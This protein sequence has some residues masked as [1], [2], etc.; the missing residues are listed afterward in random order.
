MQYFI[1]FPYG[2]SPARP[3]AEEDREHHPMPV[4]LVNKRQAEVQ[5]RDSFRWPIPNKKQ[6]SSSG[7]VMHGCG[8]VLL[9]AAAAA[10]RED[11]QSKRVNG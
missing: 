4:R 7:Y 10:E 8:A 3:E 5:P 1:S 2:L 9:A 6:L 11:D